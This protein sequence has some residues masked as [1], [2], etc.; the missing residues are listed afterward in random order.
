VAE[1]RI[2]FQQQCPYNIDQSSIAIIDSSYN[3]ITDFYNQTLEMEE[4]AKAL[5]N[6]ETLFDIQKSTYK[7]LKDCK[8]EL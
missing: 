6:L 7:P 8:A 2:K 1:F 5:N 3:L 4:E